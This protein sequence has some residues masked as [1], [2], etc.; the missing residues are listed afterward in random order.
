MFTLDYIKKLLDEYIQAVSSIDV[1]TEHEYNYRFNA[2]RDHFKNLFNAMR[3]ASPELLQ[4][5]FPSNME[6]EEA[7]RIIN[8]IAINALTRYSAPFLP[9]CDVSVDKINDDVF[10]FPSFIQ[11]QNEGNRKQN[12][13]ISFNNN[14]WAVAKQMQ[15]TLL[16]NMLMCFSPGKLRF[17][18][19]DFSMTGMSDSVTINYQSDLYNEKVIMEERD[20]TECIRRLRERI[21]SVMQKYGDV[22]RY[23]E[24]KK[25]IEIPYEVV[26]LNNYP[27]G[28]ERYIG[29]MQPL[30]ENGYRGG[31]YFV[32][33]HNTSLKALESH[34]PDLLFSENKNVISFRTNKY[35]GTLINASPLAEN[36][37]FIEEYHKYFNNDL[38]GT[39]EEST[40]KIDLALVASTPFEKTSS[41]ITAPIGWTNEGKVVDFKM[42]VNKGHYHAFVIGETGSGKSRFLHDIIISMI[43]KYS[44]EDVELFLMDFKGVEFNDYREIKHSRVVLVD[45]ADERI[46]YEVISELKN[47][48]E[49]RQRILASTGASDV[50]EFNRR[51]SGEHLSQ[52]ILVADECQTLFLQH[53]GSNSRQNKEMR[54]IIALIAQQGRA[55]GV[56]LLLATQSLS[57]APELGREILN[58][59]GEHYILPCLPAD[60]RRLVPDHEQQETEKVV[61]KME[62]GKGQCYYQGA[63]GKFI[64]TFNFIE[65]GE[66]QSRLI[67][68]AKDKAKEY[69][70][71][72]QVYFSGSL[73]YD[74]TSIA[75]DELE[76]TGRYDF[77]SS[78]GKCIS[79]SQK[80]LIIPLIQETAQNIM[81]LGINDKDYVTRTT[82]NLLVSSI[83]TSKYKGLNSDIVVIDCL[84]KKEGGYMD[85]LSY[86]ESQKLCRLVKEESRKEELYNLCKEI[87]HG[88]SDKNILLVILGEERFR[89]LKRDEELNGDSEKQNQEMPYEDPIAQMNRL[90]NPIMSKTHQND[91]ISHIKTVSQAL[92]FILDHGPEHGVHT[93]MQLD[94]FGNYSLWKEGWENP[95]DIYEKF[96]H[97][98]VLR[99]NEYDVCRLNMPEEICP[100]KLED[101]GE[102]LRA[103]YY[104]EGNNNEDLFTPYI[105]PS[106]EQIINILN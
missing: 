100:E 45:R 12:F 11:W 38:N 58:Q 17:N 53:S 46:T 69:E 26:V 81:L 21:Q 74:L 42:D 8:R 43:S 78:P 61:S 72:G 89:E 105:I 19:F 70:S 15:A 94:R 2:I 49:E 54:D 63:D 90:V 5:N 13:V 86:L 14:Q 85:L 31:I 73:K 83:I 10:V 56:H 79:I 98:I 57:N 1:K 75:I 50:D 29:Q 68:L 59:I 60:A 64:F 65:K 36:P 25:T 99:S 104:N 96:C 40:Q 97:F 102:R 88:C 71:N 91:G 4:Y 87:A 92:S 82:I 9:V 66:E 106:K 48:M 24:R 47:K 76:G 41:I 51:A 27:E 32:V 37:S 33:M 39:T 30:F 18:I 22:A 77:I 55:Y 16:H 80:P 52:I 3:D 20:A 84:K 28:Y 95:K 103:Y 34:Y 6:G 7:Q 23:N 35:V 101:N 93:I 62:K 67:N 44:P